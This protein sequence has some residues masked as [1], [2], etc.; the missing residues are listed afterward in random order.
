MSPSRGEDKE[1]PLC[2]AETEASSDDGFRRNESLG[3]STYPI[4]LN[5]L[6]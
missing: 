1:S 5:N 2:F 3:L 6:F 4:L